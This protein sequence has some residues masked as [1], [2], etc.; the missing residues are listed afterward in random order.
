MQQLNVIAFDDPLKAQEFLTAAVRLSSQNELALQDAVF[1]AKT[2]DDR[3][4]VHETTDVTSGQGAMSGTFW[5]ML[6]GLFLGPVGFVGAAAAGA[7]AG[8]LAGK[9][10][11]HGVSDEFVDQ[12][13]DKV[14]PGT[15]ALVLLTDGGDEKAI[16]EELRRFAGA[17][18]LYSNLPPAARQ[19]IENALSGGATHEGVEVTSEPPADTAAGG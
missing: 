19:D 5:G 1:V 2:P 14:T 4:R 13:K 6:F 11:D 7:G 18:L 12:I 15:T 3:V 16:D 9:L 8:A 17:H 10:I